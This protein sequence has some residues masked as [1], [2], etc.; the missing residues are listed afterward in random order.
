MST[1]KVGVLLINLGTP[2]SPEPEAVG[3]Y[4]KEFLND[5]L[6]ID[7]PAL[8]RW[9]LVNILIVP[10]RKHA[11]SH[12]YKKIWTDRG[13]PLAYYL[14]DLT[15]GLQSKV[16]AS[17]VVESAMRYGNPSI[18]SALE[19]LE[20]IPDLTQIVLLPLYPQYSLAATESSIQRVEQL[21]KN[22]SLSGLPRRW[23]RDFFDHPGMVH[24]F[25][26][27]TRAEI[28]AFQPDHLI[29][30]FHGL[31]E[32]HVKNTDASKNHCLMQ[33][34]CCAQITAVN[35]SCYRAQSYATARLIA[36]ELGLAEDGYSVAFQSRL[37]RTPWIRPYT[38]QLYEELPK[39]GKKRALVVSPSFVA[40]CLET[41][42]EIGLR[43]RE[44]WIEA[45]GEDL[46]LAP[47]LNVHPLWIDALQQ[48]LHPSH[49]EKAL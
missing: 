4:L 42:E 41:I 12:A 25:A 29:F 47:S 46:K 31:P 11:S 24:A 16:G 32:R 40:D 49:P 27:I 39:A 19:R 34:N 2:D 15:T 45:G 14:Q 36:Q 8:L 20:K 38:D 37:G 6:V 9:I 35:R 48:M 5:P 22:S 26:E 23:I 10:R 28:Q 43:G 21:L 44:Q 1:G 13:S 17:I 7:I 3:R 30:S 33:G 18:Q